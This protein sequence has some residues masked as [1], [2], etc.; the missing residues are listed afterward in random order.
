MKL[1]YLLTAAT[2]ALV[3]GIF[4]IGQNS[5]NAQD[6]ATKVLGVDNAN[7]SVATAQKALASYTHAHMGASTQVFL[8]ASYQRAVA[9][10]D[11]SPATSGQVYHDAQAACA[12]HTSAVNQANCVQ[13]YVNAHAAPGTADL[14]P[15]AVSKTPYTSSYAS[16]RWTPDLAGI[17]LLAGALGV[18]LAGLLGA[19]RPKYI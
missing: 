19:T 11:A 12:S 9:A 4:A 7:Q 17:L 6:L 13:S 1:R 3:F 15:T 5:G 8:S 2:A 18:I 14:Q 16:P 10:T